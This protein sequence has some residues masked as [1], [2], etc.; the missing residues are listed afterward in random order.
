M[1]A[2]CNDNRPCCRHDVP[3]QPKALAMPHPAPLRLALLQ[4]ASPAGD[5]DLA[6]AQVD[7][8]LTAAGAMGAAMLVTPEVFL[9]GYNHDHIPELALPH[10]GAWQTRLAAAC[11]K[12]NCG[13]V[14]GYAERDGD[15]LYN[16][17]LALDATGAEVTHFRKIQLYGPREAALYT[18]GDHYVSFDLNGHKTSLLI[19]YDIEFAPHVAELARAGVELILVPTANMQPF[20]HVAR[21]TVPTMA[22]NHG[23]SIVYA[24]YC[25][26]EGDLTYV[27][28]SLIAGPHGEV[29][30]QAGDGPALLIADLPARTPALLS[31]QL[32]DQR[33]A[34]WAAP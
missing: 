13:L 5:L 26:V 27:G 8:A 1:A 32:R 2:V 10:G 4:S 12:A 14:L 24:N 21:V 30:A 6:M 20:T 9:P 18:P 25:G 3:T 7:S 31:T 11:A 19:C 33:A 22:A 34:S 16:S 17:A 15:R 23:T 29:M 28:L